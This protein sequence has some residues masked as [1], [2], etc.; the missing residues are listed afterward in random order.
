MLVVQFYQRSRDK[1]FSLNISVNGYDC[2][3]DV[4]LR[5]AYLHC[6]IMLGP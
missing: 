5:A 3:F 6:H 4:Q 2:W 1:P